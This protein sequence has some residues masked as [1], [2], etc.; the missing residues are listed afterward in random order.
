MIEDVRAEDGLAGGQ[1][2]AAH[3][4]VERQPGAV[5]G[6]AAHGALDELVVLHHQDE[7]RGRTRKRPHALDELVELS[8]DRSG[9]V[10]ALIDR[11]DS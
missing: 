3:A 10:T 7:G 6:C 2:E 9:H 11:L 8:L 1:R 5:G 4:A